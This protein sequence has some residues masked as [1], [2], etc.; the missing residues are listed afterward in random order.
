MRTLQRLESI[1][2]TVRG[3]LYKDHLWVLSVFVSIDD[4]HWWGIL[5]TP[6][7]VYVFDCSA[8]AVKVDGICQR[9]ELIE[10]AKDWSV[11]YSG[12]R[13]VVVVRKYLAST[14]AV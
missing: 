6:N 1:V 3:V 10:Q 14:H 11:I 9:G 2:E 7:N 8:S 12:A 4:V 13:N 5:F